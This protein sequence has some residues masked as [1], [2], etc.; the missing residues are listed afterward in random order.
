MRV[1][2]KTK[3]AKI[4]RKLKKLRY[5]K[6]S[7][8][9]EQNA[10]AFSFVLMGIIDQNVDFEERFAFSMASNEGSRSAL[11]VRFHE[12]TAVCVVNCSKMGVVWHGGSSKSSMSMNHARRMLHS[13]GSFGS[14]TKVA[15]VAHIIVV[16]III[17]ASRRIAIVMVIV[18]VPMAAAAGM[19]RSIAVATA[20]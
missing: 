1:F 13:S 8:Q 5:Y 4:L 15:V 17:W 14:A 20:R 3:E 12:W 10:E 18:V 19:V 7:S 16:I 11:V 6:T 9:R 2:P